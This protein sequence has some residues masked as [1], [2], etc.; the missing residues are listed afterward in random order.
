METLY[1]S[2]LKYEDTKL[3][4]LYFENKKI[5]YKTLLLNVRKMISFFKNKGIKKGDVV[6]TALPNIPQMVY[7]FYALDA[8]GV[9]Q[10]I[11]HPLSEVSQIFKTMKETNSKVAVILGTKYKEVLKNDFLNEYK[12]FFVNPMFEANILSKT[13]FNIAYGKVKKSSQLFSLDE[14]KK[15]VEETNIENRLTSKPSI[16]LHSGGTT[17]L[18]KVI[19]LS[20]EAI[21]N[22]SKKVEGI[23]EKSIE[24]KSMLAV[25]PTFHGFGLGMGIHGPLTN[26]ASSALMMKFNVKKVIKWINQ[27][28][29]NLIIG[30]P[31]LYR[32][33]MKEETFKKANLKN[34][35]F[36]FVGGDNVLPSLITSFNQ[37]MEESNSD[38]KM[39]E[40]YGLTETV[41]VAVVNTKT[42]FK[43]SSVGKTLKG[44]E[45]QIRDEDLK[46]LPKKQVGE[47]FIH[48][49]TLMN[50]YL[51]DIENTEKTIV[52]IDDKKW[53][54][55]GD[56]GYIDE[57][58]F[59]FLK[60]RIKRLFK[61]SGMN[62][63]PSEVEKL[64]SQLD[65]VYDASLEFF[66][67][68]KICTVLFVI[69]KKKQEINQEKF[70]EEIYNY[71]DGKV[72]KYSIPSKIVFVEDFPKTAVGKI[73]H[74]A[75]KYPE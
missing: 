19:V 31:L 5:S 11:V 21:N 16:Y 63:Y 42:N 66:S 46:L 37:M 54:R 10:N 47:V 23:V 72:L 40:G 22:L 69:L 36:C 9:I 27:N 58:G 25:L 6:T 17:A 52:T 14:Y 68:P 48:G 32:K 35:E 57:E 8:I 18:P 41:T 62:V 51:N 45:I 15:E 34:L 30:V 75:F 60:G 59:L 38:C 39:L 28:K 29:V 53:V 74:K 71:L 50:C 61:I 49:N 4:A 33:L 20:D 24:G 67:S 1:Q 7:V 56:L 55:T 73:D 65:E 13:V 26:G 3:T 43:L 2:L 64:V 70:K 12:F 44:I